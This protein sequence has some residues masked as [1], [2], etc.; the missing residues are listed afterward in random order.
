ML[1][2]SILTTALCTHQYQEEPWTNPN[3]ATCNPV[4]A[5]QLKISC[6]VTA[7][8]YNFAIQ[9]QR[10]SIRS[11]AGRTGQTVDE[12]GRYSV[13]NQVLYVRQVAQGRVSQLTINN[14]TAEDLGYYWCVVMMRLNPL[15]NPSRILHLT[16]FCASST[17]CNSLLLNNHSDKSDV[18]CANENTSIILQDPSILQ[19]KC[20]QPTSTPANGE[21][22]ATSTRYG[23]DPTTDLLLPSQ[24]ISEKNISTPRSDDGSSTTGLPSPHSTLIYT[25]PL[26][27]GVVSGS[28]DD[29]V[30]QQLIWMSV[31]IATAI[32][33]TSIVFI[34][35]LIVCT[36]TQYKRR[37]GKG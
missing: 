26:P 24:T 7:V 20:V 28:V 16:N 33:V 9:W 27:T 1:L 15:P 14:V 8:S 36:C 12:G 23:L 37:R 2:L 31:G 30:T 35:I 4:G 5:D 19:S 22:E 18:H 21:V 6:S 25:Q 11:N 34:L 10:S 32:V 13:T 17:V 29:V 3:L